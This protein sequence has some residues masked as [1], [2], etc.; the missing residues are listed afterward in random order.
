MDIQQQLNEIRQQSKEDFKFIMIALDN[1]SRSMN[2][3]AET[4]AQ[5]MVNSAKEMGVVKAKMARQ[6]ERFELMLDAVEQE[7]N[8]RVSP[9]SFLE[10]AKRVEALERKQPPA[11]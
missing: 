1:S 2:H 3:I 9:E 6:E 10:L 4:I 11:A 5:E 8:R 7:L